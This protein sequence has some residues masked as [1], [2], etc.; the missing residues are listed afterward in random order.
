MSGLARG[1]GRDTDANAIA[2]D[3][4]ALVGNGDDDCNR[5]GWRSLRM[6]GELTWL[7][8]ADLLVEL[9]REHRRDAASYQARAQYEK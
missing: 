7:E 2:I 6:P 8:V 3:M 4:N 9:F 5:S 1:A